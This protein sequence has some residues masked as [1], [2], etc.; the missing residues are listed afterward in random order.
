MTKRLLLPLCACFALATGCNILYKQNIQQGNA[1]EQEDLDQLE[2]GMSKNQVAFLLGTPAIQDPFHNDRWDYISSY[3]R[4]G[5]DPVRRLVTLQFES[6]TLTYMK[7]VRAGEGEEVLT[8]DGPEA[9][10]PAQPLVGVDVRDARD[11]QDLEIL[12]EEGAPSWTLQFGS[13]DARV[14]ANQARSRLAADGIEATIYGQVLGDTGFFVIRSGNYATREE[15]LQALADIE[16]RTGR[17]P[18]LV[19]PGS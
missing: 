19:T 15:A 16:A 9:V 12:G 10:T 17:R 4:R 8:A 3:A 7:G 1:L 13:Y 11:Y 6:D 5:G 2:L 14:N 18:F